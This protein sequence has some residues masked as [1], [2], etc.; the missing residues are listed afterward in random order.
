MQRF[1]SIQ[2]NLWLGYKC[3]LWVI[4]DA[5]RVARGTALRALRDACQV[6]N[7]YAAI[8]YVNENDSHVGE[9]MMCIM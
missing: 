1:A 9:G 4:G 3:R 2:K 8:K 6:E 5:S 7:E